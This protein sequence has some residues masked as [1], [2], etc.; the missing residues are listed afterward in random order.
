[1][2]KDNAHVEFNNEQH[3]THTTYW[4]FDTALTDSKRSLGLRLL[5]K[6]KK[7]VETLFDIKILRNQDYSRSTEY[8]SFPISPELL[9]LRAEMLLGAVR[10]FFNQLGIVRLD[11]LIAA[12]IEAY[13]R[14]F[15]SWPHKD[16]SGGMGFN[17]GLF[18]YCFVAAIQ[19]KTII[20]SGVWRGYTTFLL[21]QA[22]AQQ[23]ELH[24]FDINLSKL[25]W[26]SPRAA[27]YEND[28]SQTKLKADNK[29]SLAFFDDHV[30]HYDRFMSGHTLGMAGMVFDDD[31][32]HLSVHSDGWPPIPTINMLLNQY[33][34]PGQFEWKINSNHGVANFEIND[35][36]SVAAEYVF[37]TPPDLFDI[38]GYRDSSRTTYVARKGV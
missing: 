6:I 27:Y 9:A 17:N 12:D 19:P 18:L 25:R 23:S 24:C 4:H 37:V 34:L 20:E 3:I 31:V 2:Q 13:Q 32:T 28:M 10:Q 29:P 26:R 1:M 35:F 8:V 22:S 33:R 15:Q 36:A 38:T 7:I 21:D 30:S 16:L 5:V 14:V 11:S